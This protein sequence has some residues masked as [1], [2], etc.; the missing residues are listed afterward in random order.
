MANNYTDQVYKKAQNVATNHK[1]NKDWQDFVSTKLQL[2][3]LLATDGLAETYVAGLDKLREKLEASTKGTNAAS[4]VGAAI[5]AAAE[6]GDPANKWNERAA[7]LKMLK[8]LYRWSKRGAQNIWIYSPPKDYSKWIFEQV[9]GNA[10]SV[11]T[12]LDKEE[13][14]YT[15]ADK[16]VMGEAL[17]T[18]LKCSLKVEILLANPSEAT[19][20]VVKRWFA[21]SSTTKN[22]VKADAATLLAGFKKITNVCNSNTL[23]FPD[24]PNDRKSMTKY[25]GLYGSVWPGGEGKFPVIYLAGAFKAA[26]ASGKLWLC[27][28]TIIHEAS[29]LKVSTEDKRY[30]TRGLKPSTAFPHAN[31]IVNAD[32]WGYFCIDLCG[33]LS[34]SDRNNVLK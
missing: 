9:S 12:L 34:E 19:L 6:Q 8:H 4:S 18:A 13:E 16:K 28:Q 24:D 1:Y 15:D 17:Q 30:D 21:D 26:G 11:T 32:S 23:I 7:T 5:V 22:Q 3:G 25:G 27:A 14:I 20:N 33:H 31:A 29:H 2:K 10:T